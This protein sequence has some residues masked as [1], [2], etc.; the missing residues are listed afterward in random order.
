[1]GQEGLQK[2][3]K[4][5]SIP[6]PPLI[7]EEDSYTSYSLTSVQAVPC[8]PYSI[9]KIWKPFAHHGCKRGWEADKETC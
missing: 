1:M 2:H 4:P 3:R 6:D 5:V 9:V 7:N 8:L